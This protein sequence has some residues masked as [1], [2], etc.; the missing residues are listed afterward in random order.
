MLAELRVTPVGADTSFAQLVADL[1][2]VLDASPL[3]YRMH[4]MGTT[5]EGELDPILDLVRHCHEEAR[6]HSG[7]VLIELALDDRTTARGE[8]ERGLEHV[9]DLRAETPLERVGSGAD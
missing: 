7:R 9:R 6:K 4:A 3:Q 8:I 2:P 5:V 1:V